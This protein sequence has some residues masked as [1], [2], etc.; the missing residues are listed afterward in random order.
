MGALDGFIQVLSSIIPTNLNPR[1]WIARAEDIKGSDQSFSSITELVAFHPFKMKQGMKGRIA[2]YPAV[3]TVTEFVLNQDPALLVDN[4]KNSIITEANFLQ[5]WDIALQT[6]TNR[7]RVWAYAPDGPGGGAPL[8]PYVDNPDAEPSWAP[9]F[10]K[11]KGHRWFRFRDDDDFVIVQN[12]ALQDVKIYTNW[13]VPIAVNQTYENGDFIQNKFMRRAISATVHSGLG[14]MSSSKWYIV[15]QGIVNVTNVDP[16]SRLYS[17]F[18]RL[19]GPNGTGPL[20]L[21]E[22][23]IFQYETSNT[24]VFTAST[25]V[26]ETT[27]P[28]PRTIGG[29]PNNDGVYP[30]DYAIGS[31]WIDTVPLGSAQLWKI[32]GQKSVYGQLKSDWLIEKVNEDPNYI[33]YSNAAEPNPNTLTGDPVNTS[34]GTGTGYDTALLGAGWESVYNEHDYMARRSDDPGPNIYT[35]WII[36]KIRDESGEYEDFVFKLGPLIADDGDPDIPTAPTQRDPTNEGW[37]DTPVTESDTEINYVS[38]ARKFFNGSLKTPWSVPVPYTGKSTFKDDIISDKGDEFKY[39]V[40]EDGNELV[41]PDYLI[42]TA[43]VFKGLSKLWENADVNI[44]YTWWKVF[45]ANADVEP[46]QE[47]VTDADPIPDVAVLFGYIP[48]AGTPGTEGYFR[49]RQRV[50]IKP[51]GVTGKAVFK[52]RQR[53]YFTDT[54]YEDFIQEYSI[55][56][57]SDG[58]DAKTVVL[59][60]DSYVAIWDSGGSVMAPDN[61]QMRYYQNNLNPVEFRFK[62]QKKWSTTSWVNASGQAGISIAGNVITID[63]SNANIFTQDATKQEIRIGILNWDGDPST[64]DPDNNQYS[65]IVTVVKLSSTN[66]GAPG[67]DSIA[68]I[69]TNEAHLMILDSS[70]GLPLAGET[71]SSGAASS[72]VQVYEGQTKKDYTTH[73]TIAS[74]VSDTVGVTFAHVASGTDRKVYVSVW[75]AN[76]RKAKCTITITYGA[77]TLTK[78][79]TVATSLDAPGAVILDID[80]NKGFAFDGNDRSSKTLTA[81]VYNDQVA[82]GEDNPNL[83]Y[84]KWF[85]NGVAVAGPT[86]GGAPSN[87][88]NRVINHADVRF[89]GEVLCMI[90]DN[91]TDLTGTEVPYRTRT[92]LISDITDTQQLIMWTD[93]VSKP[94]APPSTSYKGATAITTAGGA[95]WRKSTD[96]YWD[97]HD[98]VWASEGAEDPAGI[99]DVGDGKPYWK[100][101]KVY[102]IKGEQGDQGEAGGFPFE[103]YIST[104]SDS[105]TVPAFGAGGNTSTIAQM[106]TA[107]WRSSSPGQIPTSGFIWKTQRFYSSRNSLGDEITFDVNGYPVNAVAFAGSTW[108]PPT[109]ITTKDGTNGGAGGAGNNGWSIVP[110]L[111]NGPGSLPN[112]KVIQV[113]D[114]IGGGGAKPAGQ[115][116]YLSSAGLT[117]D[118]NLA[119]IVGNPIQMQYNASNNYLQWKYITEAAGAW[120]NLVLLGVPE[121]D[122]QEGGGVGGLGNEIQTSSGDV[123]LVTSVLFA[124]KPYRRMIKIHGRVGVRS[125]DSGYNDVFL[126]KLRISYNGGGYSD[127]GNTQDGLERPWVRDLGQWVDCNVWGHFELPAN[128]TARIRFYLSLSQGV[129][130]RYGGAKL[131][132]DLIPF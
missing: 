57:V 76:I 29:L 86:Q 124:A 19:F 25:T 43:R 8:Y 63:P 104:G 87:G 54:S 42:L 94:S 119:A 10:D 125:D 9:I 95:T 91:P 50:V 40:D 4:A 3:G 56:D 126:P 44:E 117:A 30:G 114:W 70:T 89:S 15:T 100:W 93:L 27:P 58:L 121:F 36:E 38:S 122:I 127:F 109:R 53:V 24:F 51:G 132:C 106:V 88:Q 80:S 61:I 128:N 90:A 32:F 37:S 83:W 66:V 47:A 92:V 39:S 49:N 72:I 107:G 6:N 131:M 118:I 20:E 65:D 11:T 98:P 46:D 82:G 14:T 60:T 67:E 129:A 55:I 84:F 79:F 102:K 33:R 103:M 68:A 69:L 31:S 7:G 59:T 64:P 105:V 52:V 5:F 110:A 74:V 99:I 112:S 115:G 34:A 21:T 85:V 18:L 48:A 130:A 120:R 41:T 1:Q 101:T 62:Y 78:E 45:D 97:T 71:G 96:T 123:T 23:K 16:A 12:T 81:R 26:I 75:G 113:F 35:S 77:L 28:P 13:T 17:E 73:W 22:G 116:Q 111:V 2:N 108:F